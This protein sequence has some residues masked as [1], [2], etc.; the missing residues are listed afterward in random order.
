MIAAAETMS[1][2]AEVRARSRRLRTQTARLLMLSLASE[3]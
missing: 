1:G 3:G 2:A